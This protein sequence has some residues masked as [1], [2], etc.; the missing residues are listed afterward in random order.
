[1]LGYRR[2]APGIPSGKFYDN[3]GWLV[4]PQECASAMAIY[5]AL[6]CAITDAARACAEHRS[7]GSSGRGSNGIGS[8]NQRLAVIALALAVLRDGAQINPA[9]E[10]EAIGATADIRL[11]GGEH[12]GMVVASIFMGS[13]DPDESGQPLDADLPPVDIAGEAAALVAAARA[14]CSHPPLSGRHWWDNWTAFIRS[15]IE[16]GGFEVS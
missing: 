7:D 12:L 14:G 4:H 11:T 9:T 8:Q 3:D 16:S 6:P 2:K 13:R 10:A 15:G 5:D 1:M